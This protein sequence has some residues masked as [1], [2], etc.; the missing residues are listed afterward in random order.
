MKRQY[1]DF[2][3]TKSTNTPVTSAKKPVASAITTHRTAKI[4]TTHS[5]PAN[6]TPSR[7]TVSS[8]TSISTHR[9][10]VPA[11]AR[12]F[13]TLPQ[14]SKTPVSTRSAS[15]PALGVIEDLSPRVNAPNLHHTITKSQASSKI[16]AIKSQK[17]G[18]RAH[19]KPAKNPVENSVENSAK[20]SLQSEPKHTF[21]PPKFINQD[22]IK[23][24]PLS[25]NVYR[26]KIEP[27]KESSA[28]KPVT[29][30]A[31]PEKDTK[32]GIIITIIITIIL[33]AAA[34]TVAFLLLPK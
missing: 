1:M 5:R 11:S 34:G 33:G 21:I 28:K 23:K 25:K 8:R 4:S 16:T 18:N 3:P 30:I 6:L 9:T 10:V 31:K 27:A 22:K 13:V 24:R 29:I 12:N 15:S 20:K 17:I 7:H 2:V 26:K 19:V 14:A 32:V